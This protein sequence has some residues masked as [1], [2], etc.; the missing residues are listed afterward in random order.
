MPLL[1]GVEIPAEGR[2]DFQ[3]AVQVAV[4]PDGNARR[5][6][7]VRGE[8]VRVCILFCSRVRF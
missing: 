2:G 4:R 1:G 6:R 5:A 7:V 8:D 3:P